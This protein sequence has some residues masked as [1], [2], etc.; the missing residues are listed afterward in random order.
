MWQLMQQFAQT[1]QQ[2]WDMGMPSMQNMQNMQHRCPGEWERERESA[3]DWTRESRGMRG[4]DAGGYR[5]EKHGE[6]EPGRRTGRSSWTW[7]NSP[8]MEAKT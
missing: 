4:G 7:P 6:K 5:R 8:S 1:Q 2:N 3:K